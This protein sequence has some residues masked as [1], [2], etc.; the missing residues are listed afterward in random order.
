MRRS[1]VISSRPVYRALEPKKPVFFEMLWGC[2]TL[3]TLARAL[4]STPCGAPL[5]LA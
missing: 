1:Q 4:W 3:I 2:P 5:S